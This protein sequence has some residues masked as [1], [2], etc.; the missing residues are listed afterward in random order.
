[1]QGELAAALSGV[2]A[3]V[4]TLAAFLVCSARPKRRA[5]P[6]ALTLRSTAA[7]WGELLAAAAR[8]ICSFGSACHGG[9]A[10]GHG[11]FAHTEAVHGLP[12][13]PAG[14]TLRHVA[15]VM[16]HAD[17]APVTG[18]LKRSMGPHID[19]RYL[20]YW[21]RAMPQ[22]E[23]AAAAAAAFPVAGTASASAGGTNR[24]LAWPY[25]LLTHLGARQA[26]SA[27]ADLRSYVGSYGAGGG[28]TP[29][30]VRCTASP[31]PRTQQ[32][33]QWVLSGLLPGQGAG[34]VQVE[35]PQGA[36][37]VLV[38][39]PRSTTPEQEPY[40]QAVR[41][42]GGALAP[43]IVDP[44]VTQLIREK[45]EVPGNFGM[46]DA[47]D[48]TREVCSCHLAHGLPLPSGVD[49]DALALLRAADVATQLHAA[50]RAPL[51]RLL[52]GPLL[53]A[54]CE[55]AGRAAETPSE[56]CDLA[57]W[58]GHDSTLHKLLALLGLHDGEWPPYCAA[59]TLELAVRP[60]FRGRPKQFLR[61]SYR[62]KVWQPTGLVDSGGGWL[63]AKRALGEL[64]SLAGDEAADIRGADDLASGSR[65]PL[66]SPR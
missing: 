42:Y 27:G 1:M 35:V 61:L 44:A 58:V 24:D 50:A 29:A 16:R 38:L 18:G 17:R 6:G 62:G 23:E 33:A 46:Q 31:A 9:V 3:A 14:A 20:D 12:P 10:G 19:R 43:P 41:R 28:L 64:L 53:R 36:G 8:R 13:P 34:T 32:T 4:S 45:L 26:R 5:P 48:R 60:T 40:L 56:L 65:T 55:S 59:V 39:D 7:Q 47:V 57:L 37:Q 49:A 66:M 30:G 54:L 21:V 11:L 2:A 51:L 15:V 22:P 52:V 63:P 25:G